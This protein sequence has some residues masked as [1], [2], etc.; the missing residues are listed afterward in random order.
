MATITQKMIKTGKNLLSHR[1]VR[2]TLGV[3]TVLGI[4]SA[5]AVAPA[6]TLPMIGLGET[7]TAVIS[8]AAGGTVGIAT[9]LLFPFAN[10]EAEKSTHNKQEFK[11]N[12]AVL[13]SRPYD[14][15]PWRLLE[16]SMFGVLGGF[17]GGPIG[18]VGGA[19]FGYGVHWLREKVFPNTP[20]TAS[21]R[22][23][24]KQFTL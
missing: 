21:S 15:M 19:A 24:G 23:K 20:Q 1:I 3:V 8:L 13:D 9:I 18:I 17:V 5:V 11:L 22:L 12:D 2:N 14:L 16:A 7:A 4:G 6:I 10:D